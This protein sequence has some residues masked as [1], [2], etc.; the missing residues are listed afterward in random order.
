[1]GVADD[2]LTAWHKA[3]EGDPV[4]IFGGIVAF[5]RPVT[6]DVVEELNKIFLEVVIAP[7][8]YTE[9]AMEL[10]KTKKIG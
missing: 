7:P 6:A 3:Y 8:G 2:V 4:S 5:N 1:M 9:E 10:L